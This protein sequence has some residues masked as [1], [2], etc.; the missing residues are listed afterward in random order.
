MRAESRTSGAHVV[1]HDLDIMSQQHRPPL[2]MDLHRLRKRRLLRPRTFGLRGHF[3]EPLFRTGLLRALPVEGRNQGLLR[4]RRPPVE[5]RDP[6][7]YLREPAETG[8]TVV[9]RTDRPP[10]M[11]DQYSITSSPASGRGWKTASAS[12]RRFGSS[13]YTKPALKSCCDSAA[14]GRRGPSAAI[15]LPN[16]HHFLLSPVRAVAVVRDH[17]FQIPQEEHVGHLIGLPRDPSA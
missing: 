17:P 9:V 15:T 10:V 1:D 13:R 5:L 6:Y 7:G 4:R 11:W 8:S 3:H 12:A 2:G 14:V 16:R